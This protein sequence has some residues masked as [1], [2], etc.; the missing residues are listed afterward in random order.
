MLILSAFL[1]VLNQILRLGVRVAGS[2]EIGRSHR[3]RLKAERESDDWLEYQYQFDDVDWY[4]T[5]PQ[6]EDKRPRRYKRGQPVDT[7]TGLP[8]GSPVKAGPQEPS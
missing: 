2:V 8:S 3:N 5:V 6:T 1:R 4:A 7:A